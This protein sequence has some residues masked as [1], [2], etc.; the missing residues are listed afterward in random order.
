MDVL[1]PN[2]QFVAAPTR[3]PL[4]LWRWAGLGALLLAE[5]ILLSLRFDA[6]TLAQEQEWWANV[7]RQARFIPQLG[8][9]TALAVLVFGGP[10]WMEEFQRLPRERSRPLLVWLFLLGHLL[11]FAL[12]YQLTSAV[13]EGEIRARAHP[14][15]WVI[16]WLGTALL[17]VG[18]WAGAI[19]PPRLWLGLVRRCAGTLLLGACLGF[20]AWR[21]GRFTEQLWEPLGQATLWLVRGLLATGY[22]DLVWNPDQFVVGT[23]RFWVEIAPQCSGY[24]GIGLIAIFLSFYLW[25]YRHELRFPQAV[26]L[27]PLGMAVIWLANVVRIAALIAVGNVSPTVALAGFH[28]QAGW[29]AFNAVSLGLIAVTRRSRFFAVVDAS[30]PPVSWANATAAFLAPLFAF[31]AV[32]MLTGAFA[33]D[34]D[35]LYP[36]RVLAAGAL[37]WRFRRHYVALGWDFSWAAVAIGVGV[38]PFWLALESASSHPVPAAL[39]AALGGTWMGWIGVWLLF[40]VLGSV[41][42]VP[43]AEELAFRGYLTR[44]LIANDFQEVPLGR[45]SWFS[46][47]A[48]SVLFGALHNSRPW[49]GTLAG[50]CYALAFYRR[51][52]LGDAVVAHA[53]TNALLAAYV[54]A[55]GNWSL[56]M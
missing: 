1:L 17:T 21:A 53:I 41:I 27:L 6:G 7:L 42:V 13:L 3:P 29:I 37:L 54:L 34:V 47:L 45:F 40:R 43:L 15:V 35:W 31:L 55:T 46:F 22:R 49:A 25:F 30:G 4:P 44:R 32:A 2:A 48:S 23:P 20:L 26:L 12:F 50:V 52:K 24:E 39:T 5:V 14:G 10:R 38:F 36:L 51:G 56:W 28:S 33:V 8:I 11:L 19:L 9:V 16:G 18:C